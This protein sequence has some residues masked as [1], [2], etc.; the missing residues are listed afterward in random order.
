MNIASILEEQFSV[1]NADF[2]K[3]KSYQNKFGGRVEKLLV[4]MGSLSEDSLPLLYSKLMNVDYIE[5]VDDLN[6][7]TRGEGGFGSTG[8][9]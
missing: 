8:T 7:T 2:E 4:N 9:K 3:A 1:S 5:E 6:M